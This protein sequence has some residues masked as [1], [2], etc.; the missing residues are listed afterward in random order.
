MRARTVRYMINTT[1][2]ATMLLANAW[3]AQPARAQTGTQGRF[4]LQYEARWGQAILPPGDYRFRFV[5][6]DMVV[7]SDAKSQR[8]VAYEPVSIRE[9][10]KESTS[11]LLI[12]TQG[13]QRVVYSLRIAELGESFVYERPPAH[14]RAAEEARQTQAVRVIVASE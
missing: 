13:G 2:F 8:R 10:S 6:N 3:F 9:D 1:L 14:G 5:R 4:T 12:G 7:I 11:S